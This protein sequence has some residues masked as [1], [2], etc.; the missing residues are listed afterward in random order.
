MDPLS[1]TV[2]LMTLIGTC[3]TASKTLVKICR[4]GQAPALLQALNNEMSDLRLALM[5]IYEHLEKAKKDETVL[6]MGELI[7]DQTREKVQEVDMIV[8]YRILRAGGKASLQV[9]PMAFLRERDRLCQLQSELRH[10]R[11]RI[12]AMFNH[13]LVRDTSNIK[14]LLKDI[15]TSNGRANSDTQ[16]SLTRIE[17]MLR[18]TLG[19]PSSLQ[20][21]NDTQLGSS[22][23]S[24][25]GPWEIVELSVAR[26]KYPS[27]GSV[28][29]CRLY[30]TRS[31]YACLGRLLIG[32]TVTPALHCNQHRRLR[33]SSVELELSYFFPVWFLRYAV[34]LALEVDSSANIATSLRVTQIIPN[35]HLIF[36]YIEQGDLEG[37]SRLL[38]SG[39]VSIHARDQWG[40][41]LLL[42][43]SLLYEPRVLTN[44]QC[45]KR[46]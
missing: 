1:L 37:I 7:F 38:Y 25:K 16:A 13:L 33:S 12:T 44:D 34:T 27:V 14:I 30:T 41:G 10:A 15:L 26:M 5:D 22:H 19:K 8:Q 6:R 45:S 24:L 11:Q 32:Y 3:A 40:S 18:H 2:G 4:L 39:E 29:A 9:K 23:T 36:N 35:D 31:L 21:L 20:P 17:D 43:C 46:S 42:V 28:C